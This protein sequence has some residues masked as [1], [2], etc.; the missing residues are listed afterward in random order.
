MV[1]WTGNVPGNEYIVLALMLVLQVLSG[2][3][4]PIGIKQLLMF[5]ENSDQAVVKPWVWILWLFVAPT[6]G[7]FVFQWYIYIAVRVSLL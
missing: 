1:N 7:S 6:I 3:A 5:L 4:G 2:L